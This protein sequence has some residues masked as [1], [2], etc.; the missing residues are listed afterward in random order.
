MECGIM[1]QMVVASAVYG[2]ALLLD[3]RNLETLNVPIPDGISILVLDASTRRQLTASAYNE[4]AATCRHVASILGRESLRDASLGDLEAHRDELTAVERARARHVN[5][6]N[7]RVMRA[8]SALAAGD[9][10][11]V[12][13]LMHES[14][15]SLRDDYEV[16]SPEL[17]AIVAAATESTGC[18]GARMTGAGFGG[19]GVA[20]AERSALPALVSQ[21]KERYRL[22]TG[23]EAAL[24]ACDSAAGA[25][26]VP[27]T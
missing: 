5:T 22:L 19:C 14:H 23:L 4:R 16:S 6:E 18:L 1:D 8:A 25:V 15:R 17:D 10:A 27:I 9:V 26:I 7:D 11:A 21:V 20:I 2:N 24:Y 12:G 13:D 3:C